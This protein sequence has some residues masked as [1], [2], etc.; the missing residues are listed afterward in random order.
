M[1]KQRQMYSLKC[2]QCSQEFTRRAYPDEVTPDC[3]VFCDMNCRMQFCKDKTAKKYADK[4]ARK[5]LPDYNIMTK[6]D[7]KPVK[8][9]CEY[10]QKYFNRPMW[11]YAR[12]KKQFSFCCADHRIAFKNKLRKEA[13]DERSFVP[14]TYKNKDT[15]FDE[16]IIVID[17]RRLLAKDV[18]EA[19]GIDKATVDDRIHS[20]GWPVVKAY[21]T[22]SDAVALDALRVP[23][24]AALKLTDEKARELKKEK[25]LTTLQIA[26]KHNVSYQTVWGVRS[27]RTFKH[28]T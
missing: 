8:L 5:T 24:V 26:K 7:S 1:R 25:G 13:Y 2:S 9:Q 27:G 21:T 23:R 19:L 4:A 12:T 16:V 14:A 20:L 22:K 3:N 11:I 15:N 18:R 6:K 28:L 17:K 10:C